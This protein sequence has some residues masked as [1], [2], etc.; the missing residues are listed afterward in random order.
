MKKS[1]GILLY[2]KEND[3]YYILLAH[4]GGPYWEN[5]NRGAWSLQKGIVENNENII[6][7][8]KREVKEETNIDVSESIEYLATKKVSN[9][10]LVI[11]FMSYFD[12]DINN[13]KS[14]EFELEWPK[15]SGIIKKY[16]EMDKLKWFSI[17]EAKEYINKS[18]LFFIN[19][20]EQIMKDI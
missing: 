13:F 7:A 3:K 10:K 6:N 2:K 12:G 19:R 15:Y 17:G 4:F 8:A 18:Q 14:N 1:A 5:I 11:M 9:N 16:S 20:F